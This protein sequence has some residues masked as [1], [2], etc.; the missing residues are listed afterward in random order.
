[1]SNLLEIGV[2]LSS[3]ARAVLSI[4]VQAGRTACE[5]YLTELGGDLDSYLA[6]LVIVVRDRGNPIRHR[7]LQVGTTQ[8]GE[9]GD[10]RNVGDGHDAGNYRDVA[11][12]G[13]HPLEKAEVVVGSKEQLCDREARAGLGFLHQQP[14]VEV[15]IALL[16]VRLRKCCNTDAEVPQLSHHRDKLGRVGRSEE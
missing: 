15:G 13:P 16:G 7:G 14:R 4:E 3:S 5:Q 2:N 1:M 10:L 8:L 11:A 12:E 6:H 9:A